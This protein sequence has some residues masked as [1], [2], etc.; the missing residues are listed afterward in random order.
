MKL[1]INI[2]FVYE[3]K[4]KYKF[5]SHFYCLRP[6]LIFQYI[7]N[8]YPFILFTHLNESKL[9]NPIRGKKKYKKQKYENKN[10]TNWKIKGIIWYVSLDLSVELIINS[11]IVIKCNIKRLYFDFW[12]RLKIRIKNK[13]YMNTINIFF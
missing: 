6:D 10:K 9:L 4:V 1:I 7:L 12:V 11:S 2:N 8:I 3:I 13:I 5:L